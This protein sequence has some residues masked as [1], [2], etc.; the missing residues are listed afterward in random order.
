MEIIA[1]LFAGLFILGG[2]YVLFTLAY[3]WIL[4]AVVDA[5]VD[6]EPKELRKTPTDQSIYVSYPDH[7]IEK[8]QVA[9]GDTMEEVVR[10]RLTAKLTASPDMDVSTLVVCWESAEG[11]WKMKLFSANVPSDPAEAPI[12]TEAASGTI[13]FAESPTR[14]GG[15]EEEEGGNL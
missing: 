2:F 9:D 11:Y 5:V 15:K 10:K 6:Q 3:C 1:E 12:L 13:E 8:V 14:I 7:T 4:D